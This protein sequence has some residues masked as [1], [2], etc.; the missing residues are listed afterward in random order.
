MATRC[1]QLRVVAAACPEL[2]PLLQGL[3]DRLAPGEPHPPLPPDTST[4]KGQ[5]GSFGL[6]DL[7]FCRATGAQGVVE[8]APG[9]CCNVQEATP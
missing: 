4:D 8:G 3:G 9:G 1:L 2:A 6:T 5:P 7:A